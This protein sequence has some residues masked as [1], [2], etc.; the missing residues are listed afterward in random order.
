MST[1]IDSQCASA[2]DILVC[3]GNAYR[4]D[5]GPGPTLLRETPHRVSAQRRET[6]GT[7]KREFI[8]SLPSQ[9]KGFDRTRER[10]PGASRVLL[11]HSLG[12]VL[13]RRIRSP[14]RLVSDE[15]RSCQGIDQC[16]SQKRLAN[17]ELHSRAG[18]PVRS[19][20]LGGGEKG[21]RPAERMA[22]LAS[23]GLFFFLK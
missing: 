20:V 10:L 23:A 18:C 4:Q 1:I 8:P 6:R 19:V 9:T 2:V 3:S 22:E 17:P 12:T 21:H 16:C 14:A 15:I 11:V 5:A 13:F 7:G